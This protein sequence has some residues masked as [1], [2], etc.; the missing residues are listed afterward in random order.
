MTRVLIGDDHDV[1]RTGLRTILEAQPNCEVVAEA[2][3]GKGAILKAIETKPGIAVID[4]SMPLI[5]GIEV[6]RQI[7]AQLP[8]TEVLIFTMHDSELV[9][10]EL[11]QAGARGSINS[12]LVGGQ[13]Q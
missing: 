12:P 8:K 3:D 10:Q 6:T 1:I 5:N 13:G 4:Y 7:R 11:L 9:I 2:A